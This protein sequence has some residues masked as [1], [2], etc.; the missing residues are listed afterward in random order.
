MIP[1]YSVSMSVTSRLRAFARDAR[2]LPALVGALTGAL[3]LHPGTMAVYWFEFHGEPTSVANML[4]FVQARMRE[5]FGGPML[6]M[7]ALFAAVG[8]LHGVAT[9]VT[10]TTLAARERTV[11]ALER[12][13]E[14][15]LPAL[16]AAGESDTLEYKSSLRWDYRDGKTSSVIDEAA[17]RTIAAFQ[18]HRGGTLLLGVDD[19]GEVL[20][21]ERDYASLRRRDRDG[22]EQFL[23]TCVQ[24]RLGASACP[25]VH[26]MFHD[27]GG[28]DLCRVL[29]EPSISP[30][31]H[32][33]DRGVEYL[34]RAG[35]GTRA[36]DVREA[37]EYMR[38]RSA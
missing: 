5:G 14:H 20:G 3:L 34:I 19:S 23:M 29:V 4:A 6:A 25:L 9:Q 15:S 28:R 18:N 7:S 12:E 8:A 24:R 27:I 38:A 1:T 32:A 37:T 10:L 36:L 33:T 11:H 26:V 22:F 31:F 13:L 17:T 16:L 21:L 35:N 2:W 30:V